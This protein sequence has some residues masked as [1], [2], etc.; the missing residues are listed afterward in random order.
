MILEVIATTLKEA[1][2][3]EIYGG[4]RIELVTGIKEGGLTPSL[5]LIEEVCETVKIPVYV[6]V[7]PHSKSFIYSESDR[8]VILKDI[9]LIKKT[10]AK[11]IVFGALLS[12]GTIDTKLLKKV[13]DLKGH[14]GLT[15]HRA[16]DASHSVLESFKE[17][18]NYP[19]ERVLTS[20]GKPNVVDAIDVINEM[21]CIAQD[22]NVSVLA[23]SG[24]NLNNVKNFVEKAHVREIHMGSGVKYANQVLYEI[25][26]ESMVQMKHIISKKKE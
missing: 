24:L 6:M 10:K 20:G 4:N 9:E 23:G 19:I 16:I 15:F 25:N 11:G 3:I 18:L 8:K 26:P 22:S 14:L 2:D 17:L 1:V 12:D 13:C 21:V 7:R 5:G